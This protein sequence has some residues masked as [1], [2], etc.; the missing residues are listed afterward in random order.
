MAYMF[1]NYCF[2]LLTMIFLHILD[3][4]GMQGILA[5]MKQKEW[6]KKQEGYKDLYKY[7]YVV[8]LLCHA[9][10]WTF[11]VMIPIFIMTGFE[12]TPSMGI[13]FVMNV[14]FH[15]YIDD[16]KANEKRIN[17]IIDQGYHLIQIICMSILYFGWR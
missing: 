13:V 1:H 5:S 3:D 7:D 12:F 4:Y 6:W 10:E 11:V 17:L 9:F 15:A 14:L 2:L 8:A 16:M